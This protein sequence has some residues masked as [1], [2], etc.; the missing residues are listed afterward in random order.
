MAIGEYKKALRVD[1]DD[2]NVH[3]N[4]GRTYM[5]A[6]MVADAIKEFEESIR[7]YPDFKEARIALQSLNK[8]K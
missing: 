1:P 4:L 7:L 8:N 2:E 5:Q 3:Y 6:G